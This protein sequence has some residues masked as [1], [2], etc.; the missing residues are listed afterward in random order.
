MPYVGLGGGSSTYSMPTYTNTPYTPKANMAAGYAPG[1]VSVS[2]SAPYNPATAAYNAYQQQLNPS[3][4]L[5]TLGDVISPMGVQPSVQSSAPQ[6]AAAQTSI[7]ASTTPAVGAGTSQYNAAPSAQGGQG[8]YGKVPG[9]VAVP[10]SLWQQTESAVPGLGGLTTQASQNILN[11]LKGQLSP[12]TIQMIQDHAASFG[13]GTGMPGSGFAIN[14]G[15][16]SLG[17]TAEQLQQQGLQNY[18][19]TIQGV[20]GL[21]QNPALMA[22]IA[23]QNAVWNAAPDPQAAAQ[24]LENQ[25]LRNLQSSYNLAQRYIPG[26]STAGRGAIPLGPAPGPAGGTGAYNP[27]QA[28]TAGDPNNPASNNIMVGYGPQTADT[29]TTGYPSWYNQTPVYSYAPEA[30][31]GSYYAGDVAG[32]GTGGGGLVGLGLD[33]STMG[34]DQLYPSQ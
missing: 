32:Y 28:Y 5:S 21:Q 20:G 14:T 30:G 26:G 23:T 1:T 10:P 25:Y 12:E 6:P 16:R 9:D 22:Q 19:S 3:L 34:L 2:H 11:E 17:L 15:L 27:I 31:T 24:A 33:L 13:V 7:A 18:L 8:A 4:R 29:T